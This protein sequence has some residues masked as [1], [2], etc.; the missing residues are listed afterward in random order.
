MTRL[1]VISGIGR[2]VTLGAA[3]ELLA[4]APGWVAVT[5]CL[6]HVEVGLVSRTVLWPSGHADAAVV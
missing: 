4:A 3:A 5:H 2:A 1:T 6:D